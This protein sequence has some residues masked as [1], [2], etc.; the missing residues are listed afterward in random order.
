MEF[1]SI[2][3]GVAARVFFSSFMQSDIISFVSKLLKSFAKVY[4]SMSS[5]HSCCRFGYV[6]G[7]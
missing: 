1:W 7:G 3:S 4:G 6:C 2:L 5:M